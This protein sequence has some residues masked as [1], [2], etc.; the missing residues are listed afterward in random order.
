[1]KP[2][3]YLFAI[4][5]SPNEEGSYLSMVEAEFFKKKGYMKDTHLAREVETFW[6]A[7]VTLDEIMESTFLIDDGMTLE[8]VKAEFENAGFVYSEELQKLVDSCNG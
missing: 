3:N 5:L 2:Q 7:G 1:M 8:E 4:N 6:P